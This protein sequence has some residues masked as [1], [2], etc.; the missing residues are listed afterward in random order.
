LNTFSSKDFSAADSRG[1]AQIVDCGFG[2]PGSHASLREGWFPRGKDEGFL[3]WYP[4]SSRRNSRRGKPGDWEGFMRIAARVSNTS[5]AHSVEVETEGRKQ[6]IGI[7]AKSAG[8]G[9]GV[10]GG[11]LLFAALATCFCNDLYRE[12]SKRAVSIHEVTVEVSGTFGGPGE[13]ARDIS[14]RVRVQADAPQ[15]EID[16]LIRATDSLA[17]IHNSLRSGCAVRLMPADAL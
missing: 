3:D 1:L 15:S 9:S 8:R 13:P 16:E 17:E 6:S 5:S 14:Y 10:N 12:A 4:F 2:Q 11:E 7:P